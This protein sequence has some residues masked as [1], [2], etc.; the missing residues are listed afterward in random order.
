MR[1]L[2]G[3]APKKGAWRCV[4]SLAVFA[5]LAGCSNGHNASST[6]SP[7]LQPGTQ[8]I[9]VGTASRT[10]LVR[11]PTTRSDRPG[12]L[13]MVLHGAGGAAA[14]IERDTQFTS[15]TDRGVT[16]VYPEAL[17]ETWNAQGCCLE[18][19]AH[20]VD[21]LGFLRAVL[22]V[23]LKS[24]Q[25]DPARLYLAGFSNGGM[26]AYRLAC[27]DPGKF[28]GLAVVAAAL[29]QSCPSP[30]AAKLIIAHGFDDAMVPLAG[31]SGVLNTG[32]LLDY[33]PI[34]DTLKV[35]TDTLACG[36]QADPRNEAG[37]MSWEWTCQ[38]GNLRLDLVRHVGH[39]WFGAEGSEGLGYR[40][41]DAITQYW[42]LG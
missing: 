10:F 19:E 11:T 6:N 34:V 9:T 16:V 8:T 13:L 32:Q 29:L 36:R 7:A 17:Y 40:V 14:G 22:D 20:Q 39:T 15:L 25:I 38:K 26:M 37:F 21:D 42:E 31:Y 30:P 33:P 28:R 41:T 3:T 27:T 2:S 18:A 23:A 4:V 24:G 12:P 35:F 1:A 5:A